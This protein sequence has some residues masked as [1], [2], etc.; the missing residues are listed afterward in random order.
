MKQKN[1]EENSQKIC[2]QGVDVFD[3]PSRINFDT[4]PFTNSSGQRHPNPFNPPLTVTDNEDVC[5]CPTIERKSLGK[6][7]YVIISISN[8]I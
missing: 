5:T 7:I 1:V 4:N 8:F 2:N 6:G 3:G